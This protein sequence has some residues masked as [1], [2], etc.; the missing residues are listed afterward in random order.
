MIKIHHSIAF[1]RGIDFMISAKVEIHTP[2]GLHLRPAGELAEFALKYHC[3]IMLLHNDKE[4][5]AKSLLGVLSLCIRQNTE[6]TVVCD[7]MDEEAALA[8]MVHFIE[9][10]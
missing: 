5:S 9:H 7:G 6:L 1:F 10:L 4:V 8:D 2:H 3:K